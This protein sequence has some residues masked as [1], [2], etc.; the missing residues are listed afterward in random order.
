MKIHAVDLNI[1][2]QKYIFKC[3]GLEHFLKNDVFSLTCKT[4]HDYSG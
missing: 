4:L 1:D 2:I 3:D